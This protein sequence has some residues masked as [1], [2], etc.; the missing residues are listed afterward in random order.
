MYGF[1]IGPMLA[2]SLTVCIAGVA[3]R[4]HQF[5]SISEARPAP[6]VNL[7]KDLARAAADR[8]Q[9]EYLRIDSAAD[10]LLKWKL[11]LKRTILGRAPF[12]S[13]VTIIFHSMLFLL[14]VVTVGHSILLDNYFGFSLPTLSEGTVD[15]LTFLFIIII[16][17]F[18]LRRIF[19]ARV[20]SVSTWR[21]YLALFATGAPFLTG[22]LAYHQHFDY[23]T[24]LYIHIIAGELMLIA[25]PFTKLVHMP[26][27]I[28]SRFMIRYE[29]GFGKGSRKWV[30]NT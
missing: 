9:D 5:F 22:Y 2:L 6:E 30:E 16:L 21:D 11:R 17:F 24:V 3:Y 7:P 20:R 18:L 15:N 14:P 28:L 4:V 8:E 19:V 1:L 12:L 27:F 23:R 26:F 25:I 13:A 10:I 29:L